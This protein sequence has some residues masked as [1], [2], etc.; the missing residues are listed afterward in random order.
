[1]GLAASQG[2]INWVVIR[3][4]PLGEYDALRKWRN[5]TAKLMLVAALDRLSAEYET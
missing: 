2:I 1:M 5:G 4:L 3:E